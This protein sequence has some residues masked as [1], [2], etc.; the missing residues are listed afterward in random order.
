MTSSKK[1]CLAVLS[2]CVASCNQSSA[3]KTLPVPS[4][5][6]AAPSTNPLTKDVYSVEELVANPQNFAHTMVTV[7]GCFVRNFELEVLEPCGGGLTREKLIWVEDAGSVAMMLRSGPEFIPYTP[8]G[9]LLFAY[10]GARDLRAWQELPSGY[11]M[12]DSEVVLLGQFET[13]TGGFGHLGAYSNELIVADVLSNKPT[14]TRPK[15]R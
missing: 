11:S 6:V 15:S 8:K 2:T 13:S 7:R 1:L 9:G 5:P 10:D 12:V 14:T 4:A 3:P